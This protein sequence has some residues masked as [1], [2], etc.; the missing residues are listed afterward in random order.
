[1][2]LPLKLA[3]KAMVIGVLALAIYLGVTGVQVYLTSRQSSNQ[4][5]QAIVVM[6]SAEYDGRP[7]PDLRARLS[8]A[9]YLYRSGR[10]PVVAVT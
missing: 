5:A 1:M 10:A 9:L 6:G 4:P 8:E 2:L 7:S 3:I